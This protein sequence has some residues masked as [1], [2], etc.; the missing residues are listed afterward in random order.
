MTTGPIGFGIL[1][2]GRITRRGLIPGIKGCPGAK[3]V[4]LASLRRGVAAEL[5]AF[6][7]SV[8]GLVAA[9]GGGSAAAADVL[10]AGVVDAESGQ[11]GG[12]EGEG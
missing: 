7:S 5:A 8:A 12:E 6:A 4:A 3:L 1:G 10:E 9:A 2:C 11:V